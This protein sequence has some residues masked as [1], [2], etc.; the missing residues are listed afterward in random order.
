MLAHFREY[1]DPPL[2]SY[3]LSRYIINLADIYLAE[4]REDGMSKASVTSS[5]RFWRIEGYDSTEL[6]FKKV[7]PMGYLSKGQITSLLQRLASK[8]LDEDQIVAASL[9]PN[10]KGY[11]PL[12]EPNT[13]YHP[14]GRYTISV[15]SNPN[16]AASVWQNDELATRKEAVRD[17]Q[18]RL[19]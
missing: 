12:L 5:K 7:L 18:G 11:A 6:L 14:G 9:R 13:D 3:I 8:Y 19:T 16:F 4:N 17:E 2:R 1:R 15:G 10:S